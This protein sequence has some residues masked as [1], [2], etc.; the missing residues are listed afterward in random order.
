[1]RVAVSSKETATL[2]CVMGNS[3]FRAVWRCRR[4]SIPTMGSASIHR[5]ACHQPI[6][7]RDDGQFAVDD[8]GAHRV[9]PHCRELSEHRW[10]ARG[11]D[12]REIEG[13]ELGA[14]AGG[15]G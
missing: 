8:D 9:R 2:I 7:L 14:V 10:Q 6:T 1:M 4:R 11:A 5:S 3:A 13:R 12:G 15:S